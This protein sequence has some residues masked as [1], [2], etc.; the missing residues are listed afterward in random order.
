MIKIIYSI[1][2]T[3]FVFFIFSCADGIVSECPDD[4]SPV[5]RATFSSIQSEVFD[6]SCAG[7][8]CHG[9][10]NPSAGLRLAGIN[11]YDNIVN[12]E[13]FGMMLV[14]PGASEESYLFARIS[15]DITSLQ[16][17]PTGKLPRS[18]IDSI[19]VWIDNGALNN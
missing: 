6:K 16:M 4:S 9:G 14:K 5:V 15:S 8:D 10:T 12:K 19:R 11:S 13:V 18:V 2:L 17:P 3:C 1:F 7:S